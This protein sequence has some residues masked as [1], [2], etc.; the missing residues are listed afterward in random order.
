MLCT[1]D[2]VRTSFKGWLQKGNPSNSRAVKT[3]R[4]NMSKE[5]ADALSN[6]NGKKGFYVKAVPVVD[7]NGNNVYS[8]VGDDNKWHTY[9]RV[10]VYLS[11]GNKTTSQTL[12]GSKNGV[13]G[14]KMEKDGIELLLPIGL[15]SNEGKASPDLSISARERV[16]IKPYSTVKGWVGKEQ[17]ADF[18]WGTNLIKNET[19]LQ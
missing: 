13:K 15:E 6:A 16:G 3:Y 8:M 5:I 2:A 11:D 7:K 9:T 18:P 4:N 19:S 1:E 12:V 14:V 17:D 10:K